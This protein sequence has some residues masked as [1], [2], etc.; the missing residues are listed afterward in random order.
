MAKN[1]QHTLLFPVQNLLPA[2]NKTVVDNQSQSQRIL[3]RQGQRKALFY[4]LKV[5]TGVQ[6]IFY[7]VSGAQFNA[8]P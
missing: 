4:G 8:I 6:R 3:Q 2:E 7:Q 5:N 1:V